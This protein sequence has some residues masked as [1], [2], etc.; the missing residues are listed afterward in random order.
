MARRTLTLAASA[1]WLA[2]RM[3]EAKREWKPGDECASYRQ[4]AITRVLRV[5]GEIVHLENG[6]SMHRSK[7]HGA[8]AVRR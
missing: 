8:Q 5:E 7:M 1:R 2:A 4:D 3:A 6:E